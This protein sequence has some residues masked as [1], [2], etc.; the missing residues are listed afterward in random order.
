VDTHNNIA[1]KLPGWYMS[2]MCTNYYTSG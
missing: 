2:L 1:L